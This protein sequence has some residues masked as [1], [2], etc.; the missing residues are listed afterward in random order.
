ERGGFFQS[1]EI[2]DLLS[3]LQVLDNPLQDLPLLAV[4]RSPLVGLSLDELA[5]VRLGAH[6][7]FWTALVRWHE[8]ASREAR[9][10]SPQSEALRKTDLFLDRFRRWRQ[11]ARRASLSRC[12]ETVLAE[13]H[14][15]DWLRAQDRGEQRHA[16]VQK[17]LGLAQHFDQFH[18]QGLFRF[19]RLIEAQQEAGA[20]PEVAPA[21]EQDA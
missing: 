3:L 16:N 15:A 9:A 7:H 19:L 4:L 21:A 1:A 6:G 17:L 13:T 5:T 20:E 11:L 10:R 18:R 14:Y 8:V 12:L 2:T